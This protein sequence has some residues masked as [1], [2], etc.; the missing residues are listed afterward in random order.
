MSQSL[1]KFNWQDSMFLEEQLSIARKSYQMS[2]VMIVK[3]FSVLEKMV[4]SID[5]KKETLP[6]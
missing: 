5:E 3:K 6:C 2:L 4:S 1:T